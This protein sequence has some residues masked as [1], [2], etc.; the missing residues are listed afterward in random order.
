M[1]D[2]LTIYYDT[3][4]DGDMKK[5][6][7]ELMKVEDSPYFQRRSRSEVARLVLIPVL[8]RKVKEYGKNAQ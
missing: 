7:D 4:R 8:A 3:K 1:N 6:I 2:N 5:M